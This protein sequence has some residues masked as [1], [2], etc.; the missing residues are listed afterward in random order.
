VTTATAPLALVGLK[1]VAALCGVVDG[2]V[3]QWRTKG[4][5]PPQEW[6][7]SGSPVW[8]RQTIEQWARE[9]GRLS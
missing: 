3:Y 6:L 1:E 7:V 9:T 8:R 4:V 5:L 2:T